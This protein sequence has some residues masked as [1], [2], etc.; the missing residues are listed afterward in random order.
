MKTIVRF[1]F[2]FLLGTLALSTAHAADAGASIQAVLISASK[3]GGPS[4]PRVA[5][6]EANLK[7]S[8]PFD[9]FKFVAEGSAAGNGTISLGGHRVELSGVERAGGEIRV[10]VKWSGGGRELMNTALTLRPGVP[11]VLGR[12]GEGEVP[13]VVLIAR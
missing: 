12:G 9:T 8:L 13:V 5:Q 6:Y 7:R 11:A 2:A 10:R 3:G 1:A 4:D